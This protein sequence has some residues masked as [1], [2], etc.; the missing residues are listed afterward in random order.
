[1]NITEARDAMLADL[2]AALPQEFPVSYVDA[3]PVEAL[4]GRTAW[5]RCTVKHIDGKQRG[6][7][8]DGTKKYESIGIACIEIFA[9]VGTGLTTGDALASD[10]KR[11]LE[12][13][14]S[15]QV[16]YRNIRAADVGMDGGYQKINIYADFSYEDHH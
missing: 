1:M 11:Y 2:T 15:S 12:G 8:G 6:F 13:L 10:A 4:D 3:A 16:W 14:R 9:P 7:G 5:A